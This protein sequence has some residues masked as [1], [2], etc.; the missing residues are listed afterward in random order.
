MHERETERASEEIV[1]LREDVQDLKRQRQDLLQDIKA[2]RDYVDEVGDTA[3]RE[4]DLAHLWRAIGR[5]QTF[6][7]VYLGGSPR[8]YWKEA[9]DE[10]KSA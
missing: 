8:D 3:V 7:Q 1:F 4:K 5:V 6:C 2:L 9:K 10:R